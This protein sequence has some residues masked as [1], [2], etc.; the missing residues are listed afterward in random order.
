[1]T[2]YLIFDTET[3]G[4]PKN[5]YASKN[6]TESWP[7]IVQI[8][9]IV[10][11]DAGTTLSEYKSIIKP[12]GWDIEPGASEVHGITLKYAEANGK[13]IGP[14]LH[15][16]AEAINECDLIIAHNF[17]F[18]D[19]VAGS[20]FV[21]AGISN[22][23]DKTKRF[24][25]M[26]ST[27]KLCQIKGNYGKFK[28]PKLSELYFKLFNEEFTDGHDALNDVRACAKCF[29]ELKKMFCLTNK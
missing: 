11:N 27:K 12:D 8:A 21:R 17:V 9:W 6:Q 19:S 10:C 28:Y 3:N 2:K 23:L 22:N 29:F 18:D 13:P 1:M 20:E 4:L 24:C 16:F 5:G 14:I 26:I 25:T 7:R 15:K